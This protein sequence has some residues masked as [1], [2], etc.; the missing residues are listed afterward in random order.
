MGLTYILLK[1]YEYYCNPT[2]RDAMHTDFF[3]TK[4]NQV[5]AFELI[6]GKEVTARVS[7]VNTIRN[8]VTFSKPII[9]VPM[10]NPHNP[11][12]IQVGAVP[13]GQPMYAIDGDMEIDAAHIL[14]TFKM[15]EGQADAYL[16]NTSGIVAANANALDGLADI[17]MSKFKL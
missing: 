4:I 1:S 3:T 10:Q 2:K 17:D 16:K 7:S 8:T 6:N 13:Y 14:T 12:D 11:S 5:V 9:F 15:P